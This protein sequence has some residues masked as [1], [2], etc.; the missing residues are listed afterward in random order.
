MDVGGEKQTHTNYTLIFKALRCVGH[1]AE[2][3]IHPSSPYL[4]LVA[5]FKEASYLNGPSVS[6]TLFL[7]IV[8]ASWFW[9]FFMMP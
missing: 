5:Y 6:A 9:T 4:T 2:I 8:Q 1:K 3:P 7:S